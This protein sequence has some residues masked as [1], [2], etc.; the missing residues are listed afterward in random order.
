MKTPVLKSLFDKV[1]SR[2]FDI[3]KTFSEKKIKN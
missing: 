2:T 3:L 1:G